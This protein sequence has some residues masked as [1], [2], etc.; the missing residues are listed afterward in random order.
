MS[1]NN[2]VK[3]AIPKYKKMPSLQNTL[4]LVKE[5]NLAVGNI[6]FYSNFLVTEFKEGICFTFENA[7]QLADM[8]REHFGEAPFGYISNRKHSYS[9]V[10]IDYFRI[11]EVFP[12]IKA[13]SAV[14]YSEQQ[15]AL[16]DFENIFLEEM[17]LANFDT[18]D[19]A[20]QW[21]ISRLSN[22]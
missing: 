12:N 2:F 5:Y 8:V 1:L 4:S 6:K 7:V 3:F 13:F 11:K 20:I 17:K 10:P 19:E 9:I 14:T 16:I 21:T 18:L 15:K 22:A